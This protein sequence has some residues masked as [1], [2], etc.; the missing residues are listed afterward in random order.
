MYR[1]DREDMP[2]YPEEVDAAA[3]EGIEFVFRSQPTALE[4]DTRHGLQQ[5]RLQETCPAEVVINGRRT[6]APLFGTKKTIRAR[7]AILAL[8]QEKSFDKWADILG[9]GTS[10]ADEGNSQVRRVYAAGD[11]VSG[12]ATVVEAIAGGIHCA[13]RILREV[14][15]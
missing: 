6:F 5:I 2:A 11:L 9:S 14:F 3:E 10:N 4:G 8:G 13:D 15:A 12:P 1:R 7:T